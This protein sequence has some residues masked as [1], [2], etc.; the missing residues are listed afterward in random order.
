MIFYLP[1]RPYSAMTILYVSEISRCPRRI[2]SDSVALS[3]EAVSGFQRPI[4]DLAVETGLCS[5]LFVIEGAKY[6]R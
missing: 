2:T 1:D 6:R 4:V 3:Y 5:A